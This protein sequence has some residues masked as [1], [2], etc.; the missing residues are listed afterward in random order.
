MPPKKKKLNLTVAPEKKRRAVTL[1]EL[2]NRSVSSLF[3]TLV[4]EAWEHRHASVIREEPAEPAKPR[5][6]KK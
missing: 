6:K 4:D 3:E 2:D 1:A 5:S